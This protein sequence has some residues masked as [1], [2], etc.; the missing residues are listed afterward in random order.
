M[1]QARRARSRR[2]MLASCDEAHLPVALIAHSTPSP[3]RSTPASSLRMVPAGPGPAAAAGAAAARGRAQ[4]GRPAPACHAA[5]AREDG[6]GTRRGRGAAGGRGTGSGGGSRGSGQR[7]SVCL[8]L[9]RPPLQ[10]LWMQGPCACCH[11]APDR[12]AWLCRAAAGGGA[13]A[14]AS[15]ARRRSARCRSPPHSRPTPSPPSL[16][17]GWRGWPAPMSW[18]T[19]T[20]CALWCLT[21]VSAAGACQPRRAGA[22]PLRAACSGL[23]LWSGSHACRMLHPLLH[24]CHPTRRARRGR[25]PRHPLVGRRQ[26]E[27]R[28]ARLGV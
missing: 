12:A 20:G 28:A 21:P 6:A 1:P 18:R 4:P 16:A 8:K 9:C 5:A 19:R 13:L 25:P 7:R 15:L 24:P 22:A 2:R 14:S 23:Q 17:G 11:A 10:R 3:M 27:G 26:P